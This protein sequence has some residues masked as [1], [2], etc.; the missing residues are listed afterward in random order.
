MFLL[1]ILFFLAAA[2]S[3]LQTET[4]QQAPPQSHSAQ[5]LDP[6]DITRTKRLFGLTDTL[7]ASWLATICHSIWTLLTSAA[8]SLH[9]VLL[10]NITAISSLRLQPLTNITATAS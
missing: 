6:N 8:A 10:I 3:D 4:R 1:R 9:L 2:L 7:L 5:T